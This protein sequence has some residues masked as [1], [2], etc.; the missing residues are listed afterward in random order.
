MM[1]VKIPSNKWNATSDIL[2]H[3][4]KIEALEK[5]RMDSGWFKKQALGD[6]ST[7]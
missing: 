4:R 2:L 3:E 7:V 5:A 1:Y 6:L